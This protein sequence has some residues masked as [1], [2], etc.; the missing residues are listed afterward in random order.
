M[1]EMFILPDEV[2]NP[3]PRA[4]FKLKNDVFTGFKEAVRRN[5]MMLAMD[6]L[7]HIVD[8]LAA[9]STPREVEN[10]AK[11]EKSEQPTPKQARSNRRTAD[12]SVSD[13]VEA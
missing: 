7:I 12:T 6:Y 5:Q 9:A 11:E 8:T 3:D 13:D 2:V 1:N 4:A 10:D